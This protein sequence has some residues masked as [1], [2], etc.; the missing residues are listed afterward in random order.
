MLSHG[1]YCGPC[2]DF[3]VAPELEAYQ[4]AM[5]AAKNIAVFFKD[6]SK[7][8]RNFKRLEKPYKIEGCEDR[9]ETLLRLAFFAVKDNFNAIIDVDITSK[10]VRTGAYQT[11]IWSGTAI[12]TNYITRR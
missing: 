7:E 9:E 4:E 6:Q 2:Y 10:K 5:T 1:A 8:T 11:Q 3:K 12:P